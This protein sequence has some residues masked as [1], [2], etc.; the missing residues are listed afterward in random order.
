M[1]D[2]M[3]PTAK[4]KKTG[5]YKLFGMSK[6]Q[7]DLEIKLAQIKKNKQRKEMKT[8]KQLNTTEGFLSRRTSASDATRAKLAKPYDRNT[9][10]ATKR[11]VK[12]AKDDLNHIAWQFENQFDTA[13]G[14][15]GRHLINQKKVTNKI[16]SL[17][18]ELEDLHKL[19]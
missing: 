10:A 11:K 4:E 19:L 14:N 15:R 8:F 2:P 6:R 18:K 9:A 3:A 1:K 13:P 16:D 17:I 7:W 12:N 5:F